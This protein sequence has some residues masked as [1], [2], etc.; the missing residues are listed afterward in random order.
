MSLDVTIFFNHKKCELS[1]QSDEGGESNKQH[2]EGSLDKSL[3]G[4][5]TDGFTEGLNSSEYLSILFN[6]L[7]NLEKEVKII[8]DR[9]N[10]THESQIKR[11]KHLEQ[12]QES[13]N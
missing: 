12:L 3:T 8:R 1:N 5:N 7:Q 13:F 11:T 6:C 9:A 4:D 2:R 10:I